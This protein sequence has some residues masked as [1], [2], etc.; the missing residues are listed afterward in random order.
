MSKLLFLIGC[1]PTRLLLAFI[2]Y[3]IDNHPLKK[4]FALFTL[5][6]GI[7]FLTIYFKGLRKTGM[8]TEG[9]P[10]WWNNLRP[11]HGFLYILFSILYMLNVKNA[12][13]ILLIDVVIGL[14]AFI[15]NYYNK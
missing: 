3:Y 1:I 7:G 14:I 10:I 12:W 5:M 15:N 9:R 8:E 6:I 2:A 11:V 4:I 13:I